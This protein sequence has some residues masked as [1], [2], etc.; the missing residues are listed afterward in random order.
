MVDPATIQQSHVTVYLNSNGVARVIQEQFD[1][2]EPM[3][4]ICQWDNK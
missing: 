3:D 2:T 4:R 1:P